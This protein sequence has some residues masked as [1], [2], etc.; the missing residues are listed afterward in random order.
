MKHISKLTAVV[1]LT[2]SAI[3]SVSLVFVRR[4]MLKMYMN[5]AGTEYCLPVPTTFAVKLT[6]T[7]LLSVNFIILL[8]A[9]GASEYRL[10]NERTRFLVQI[11]I[12]TV[13]M[14]FLLFLMLAFA[15][16]MYIPN[17]TLVG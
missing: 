16:P 6:S 10:K 14:L 9:L 7:V 5:M 8:F 17:V 3:A 4:I 2:S 15:L 12:V 11:G 13:L 1:I